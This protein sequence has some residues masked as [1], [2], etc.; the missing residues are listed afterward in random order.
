MFCAPGVHASASSMHQTR[1]RVWT[2][3]TPRMHARLI[4]TSFAPFLPSCCSYANSRS[5]PCRIQVVFWVTYHRA[6]CARVA[7]LDSTPTP[8]LLGV[9]IMTIR[10]QTRKPSATP[11]QQHG[12]EPPAANFQTALLFVSPPAR[13]PALPICTLAGPPPFHG[14]RCTQRAQRCPSCRTAHMHV[15]ACMQVH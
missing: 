4:C 3:C 12:P 15:P 8:P 13:T 9:N 10:T 1:M 11:T 5:S 6:V 7:T 14:P 2:D